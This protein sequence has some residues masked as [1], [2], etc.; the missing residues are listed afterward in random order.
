VLFAESHRAWKPDQLP[1]P[2]STFSE[3]TAEAA[4]RSPNTPESRIASALDFVDD[5]AFNGAAVRS[6]YPFVLAIQVQSGAI[7]PLDDVADRRYPLMRLP[8]TRDNAL[9]HE[10]GRAGRSP[11]GAKS[12]CYAGG[13]IHRAQGAYGGL[14]AGALSRQ[15]V[16][17]RASAVL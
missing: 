10:N 1:S 13:W 16:H 7:W 3:S 2:H 14:G 15:A 4:R 5:E 8:A 6:T 11:S 12:G 17:L 9:A